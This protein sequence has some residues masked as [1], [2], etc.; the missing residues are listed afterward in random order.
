MIRFNTQ[1]YDYNI[2]KTK[3]I[4]KN[5]SIQYNT[6]KNHGKFFSSFLNL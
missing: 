6:R 5:N 1:K 2:K 4:A 3:I